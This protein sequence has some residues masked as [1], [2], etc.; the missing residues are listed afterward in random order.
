MAKCKV[1]GRKLKGDKDIGPVCARKAQS[2]D[3]LEI[4]EAPDFIK[5]LD[6]PKEV[7]KSA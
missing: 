2:L 5:E 7:S 6:N 1:C 3:Q 4:E